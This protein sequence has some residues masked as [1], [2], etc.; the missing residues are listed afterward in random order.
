MKNILALFSK[1]VVVWSMFVVCIICAGLQFLGVG[2][3][4][5][6]DKST[7]HILGGLVS[8]FNL[9]IVLTVMLLTIN[10]IF[11]IMISTKCS[12]S[13]ILFS[14]CFFGAATAQL[15][16]S[17]LAPNIV[18]VLLVLL[19][20][21]QKKVNCFARYINTLAITGIYQLLSSCYKFGIIDFNKVF[22]PAEKLLYS[23][24]GLVFLIAIY[25]D[26]RE[27]KPSEE[28]SAWRLV[29]YP[30]FRAK[31]EFQRDHEQD[32]SEVVRLNKAEYA[33]MVVV[34]IFQMCIVTTAVA[35]N[36]RLIVF[37]IVYLFGFFPQKMSTGFNYHAST[38]MGC[39]AQSL[40]AFY[41]AAALVPTV[42]ISVLLPVCA[43]TGIIV[44]MLLIQKRRLKNG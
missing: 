37:I 34:A 35:L 2:I 8:R 1:R 44:V 42:G 32:Q 15:S 41:A 18:S 43:G 28:V 40:V 39:T 17:M 11:V 23:L 30:I 36:E 12:F 20:M 9:D 3:F 24:D 25:L 19:F 31:E 4:N 38:I 5:I 26:R 7:I 10:Y 29:V 21:E 6:P 14:I 16:D 27:E 33:V 13:I 22:S